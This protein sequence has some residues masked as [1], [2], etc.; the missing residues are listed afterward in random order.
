MEE[1]FEFL[2]SPRL[3]VQNEAAKIVA[4]LTGDRQYFEYFK[5]KNQ[6]PV[7]DLMLLCKEE[8][9]TAHDAL[10]ALVN[11]SADIS[12]IETISDAAFLNE[13]VLMMMVQF[14]L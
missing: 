7:M 8:P 5:I 12:F 4:G 11:L 10:S 13:L 14:C 9:L 1:L 3:E 6:K 2:C